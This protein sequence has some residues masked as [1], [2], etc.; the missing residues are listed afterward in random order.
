MR[1][2]IRMLATTYGESVSWTPICATGAPIGPIENG[3]MYIVRPRIE[4][5][6]SSVSS[7]RISSGSRQLLFGPASISLASADERAVLDARHVIRI[8]AREI[9]VGTQLLVE[10]KERAGLHHLL[11][12]LVVLLHGAVAPVDVRRLD[13]GCYLAHPLKQLLVLR[14]RAGGLGHC[15]YY[16]FMV[17]LT[18]ES[19]MSGRTDAPMGGGT[20]PRPILSGYRGLF[21]HVHTPSSVVWA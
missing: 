15:R 13:E 17:G 18:G 5:L 11:A 21:A 19:T 2:M 14:W 12:E 1:V 7:A 4:P 20:V 10:A 9:G 6:K 8:G 16:S 3:T